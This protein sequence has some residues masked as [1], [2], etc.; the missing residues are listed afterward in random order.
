MRRLSPEANDEPNSV[1]PQNVPNA[2][3]HT[4]SAS[5]SGFWSKDDLVDMFIA[6]DEA[7]TDSSRYACF[8]RR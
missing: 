8:H 1:A 4:Y 2:A 5:E 3:L 6:C 7:N